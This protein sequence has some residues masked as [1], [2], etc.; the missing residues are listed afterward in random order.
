MNL[1]SIQ[2]GYFAAI[3]KKG[4]NRPLLEILDEIKNGQWRETIDHLR[5]LE[6]TD[7]DRCKA[8]LPAFIVSAA[9]LNGQR[10]ASD[11]GQHTGLMQIDID[12]LADATEAN[13]IR[14]KLASDSHVLACWV[15]PGGKGVK[16]IVPINADHQT[17]KTCFATAQRHFQEHHQLTIDKHCSDPGRLCF[18]SHDPDLV[19]TSS[20]ESFHAETAVLPAFAVPVDKDSSSTSSASASTHYH[21]HNT[22]FAEYPGLQ[23][24]YKKLVTDR[25]GKI[26]SGLRNAALVE[27]VPVLYSAIAPRFIPVFAEELYMQ[28]QGVFRDL[29]DQHLKEALSLLD[30]CARDYAQK[31]LT[32]EEAT[33]YQQLAERQQAVFR[34]CHALSGIENEECP[35]PHFFLSA[36]K[37]GHRLGVLDP[38]AHR[39]LKALCRLGII[40]V[41][42]VG[43]RRAK[44]QPGMATHY[45]WLLPTTLGAV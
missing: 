27:M 32:P 2:C 29:L 24:L 21:L 19:L 30:G 15:S 39:E 13:A 42:R 28:H 23:P 20:A 43:T 41:T 12:H 22:A 16:A 35:P 25:L 1:H 9:T 38:V 11:L 31:R 17:H 5:C 6:G 7:Y 26:S 33:H 8:Q 36:E 34:I 3:T 18:V 40:R 37:L 14:Q 45:E 10:K 44:G 4:R